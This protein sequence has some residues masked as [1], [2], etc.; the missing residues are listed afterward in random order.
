MAK[1]L[2]VGALGLV[3]RAVVQ[4]F[5]GRPGLDVVGLARQI[6]RAHV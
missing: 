4:R 6:G 3:G 2:V 1:L 5:A